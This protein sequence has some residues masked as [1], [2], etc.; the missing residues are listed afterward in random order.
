VSFDS[1]MGHITIHRRL[2]RNAPRSCLGRLVDVKNVVDLNRRRKIQKLTYLSESVAS[3][4]WFDLYAGFSLHLGPAIR[5]TAPQRRSTPARPRRLRRP[6]DTIALF[7][8][9]GRKLAVLISN[10]PTPRFAPELAR[11]CHFLTGR[12]MPPSAAVGE[13]PTCLAGMA[14]AAAIFANVALTGRHATGR[15]LWACP[16]VPMCNLANT[17]Q[18]FCHLSGMVPV[19]L[20]ATQ[21]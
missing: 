12:L 3:V 5:S 2:L 7:I 19:P 4:I 9:V 17:A 15:S 6:T 1:E 14:G 21:G 13:A 18:E 16:T 20:R 11:A 10:P 8:R